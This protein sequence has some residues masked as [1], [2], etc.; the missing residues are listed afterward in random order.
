MSAKNGGT[1]FPYTGTAGAYSG[2]SLRDYFAAQAMQALATSI[3]WGLASEKTA[4]QAYK[5]ADA[6]LKARAHSTEDN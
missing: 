1:V 5:I 2:M 6:M 3:N 4:G